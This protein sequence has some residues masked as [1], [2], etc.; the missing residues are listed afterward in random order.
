MFHR[1]NHKTFMGIMVNR[2]SQCKPPSFNLRT[3]IV[4]LICL[5]IGGSGGWFCG[6]NLMAQTKSTAKHK[7]QPKLRPKATIPG[8][9]AI[10]TVQSIGF[11]I[12][13][14]WQLK[15][16]Y[17]SSCNS[18][19]PNPNYSCTFV[20]FYNVYMEVNNIWEL[21]PGFSGCN[22]D[23]VQCGQGEQFVIFEPGVTP[24]LNG[25]FLCIAWVCRRWNLQ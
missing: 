20:Y 13:N 4:V 18:N 15:I 23:T 25:E 5:F 21:Q 16:V 19:N 8:C 11:D 2:I 1:R 3:V 10:S 22:S 24:L 7:K 12:T 14:N 9:V 17:G 6:E